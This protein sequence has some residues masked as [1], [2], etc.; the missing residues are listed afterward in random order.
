M[1]ERGGSPTEHKHRPENI[2]RYEVLSSLGQGGMGIVYLA[3]DSVLGRHV[4]V[5][6]LRDDLD[7]PPQS[8][9][10]LLLRMRNEARA[11]AAIS[12]PNIVALHDMGED[13]AV[14]LYLVFEYVEGESLRTKLSK[15]PVTLNEAIELG[16]ALGRALTAAHKAGVIHR[17]VKPENVLLSKTGPKIADF[18]VARA[19]DSLITQRDVILGTPSYTAPEVLTHGDYGPASDQFSFAATMYEALAGV[20]AFAGDDPLDV[21]KKISTE[22]PRPL[23]AVEADPR[24]VTRMNGV[25]KRGL[26][27]APGDRYGAAEDFGNALAIAI[28]SRAFTETPQSQNRV[29]ITPRPGPVATE[30]PIRPSLIIRKKTQ[31]AQNVFAGI[32][33]I[34]IIALIVFGRR[35]AED[36]LPKDAPSATPSASA[37]PPPN[38]VPVR[39]VKRGP[40]AATPGLQFSSTASQPP[41]PQPGATPS[42]SPSAS[43]GPSPGAASSGSSAPS[44]P[45]AAPRAVP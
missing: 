32:G 20:R 42:A 26:A 6:V 23:E 45:S 15:G 9:A 44:A 1:T 11:A 24:I 29:L 31:R 41:V 25:L 38:V 2:G 18:G 3:R 34:V 16:R 30:T 22:D 40:D 10:E 17:D 4:A 8:K 7:I 19:P 36:A 33:L 43:P 13:P 37:V 35:S 28:E 14:G 27:K 39:P 12:H 21:V 5:K